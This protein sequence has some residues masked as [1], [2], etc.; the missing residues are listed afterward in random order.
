MKKLIELETRKI[1]NIKYYMNQQFNN[2]RRNKK[3]QE[4]KQRQL[5]CEG[6]SYYPSL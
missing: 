1:H 2:S 3:Q 6:Y 5:S 4:K